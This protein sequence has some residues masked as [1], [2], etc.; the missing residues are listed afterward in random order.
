M[1]KNQTGF[2]IRQ[3]QAGIPNVKIKLRSRKTSKSD[4]KTNNVKKE[5]FPMVELKHDPIR[6]IQNWIPNVKDLSIRFKKRIT[7]R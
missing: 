4:R 5:G 2:P 1:R 3:N 6:E 7:I